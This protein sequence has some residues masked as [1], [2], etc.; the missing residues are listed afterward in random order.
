MTLLVWKL[1]IFMEIMIFSNWRSTAWSVLRRS[2]C[3]HSRVWEHNIKILRLSGQYKQLCI[4]LAPFWCV[5]VYTGQ[6][7][8]LMTSLFGLSLWNTRFGFTTMFSILSQVLL[9]W[10]YLPSR[11]LTIATSSDLICEAV[12]RMFS[13]PSYKMVRSFQNGI[14]DLDLVNSWG[15]LMCILL[16]LLIFGT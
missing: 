14:V 8:E 7:W 9:L 1:S 6:T 13:N 2:S 15:I 4:W 12:L 5:W 3:N 11:G 10:N 16:L